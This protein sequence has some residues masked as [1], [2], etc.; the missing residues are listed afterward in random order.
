MT[1]RHGRFE[2]PTLQLAGRVAY[3]LV[4]AAPFDVHEG[5][6]YPGVATES[7]TPGR[8]RPA[9]TRTHRVSRT[10]YFWWTVSPQG[11]MLRKL[12][13]VLA[14]LVTAAMLFGLGAVVLEAIGQ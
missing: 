2:N 10:W 12:T 1:N 14:L 9:A 13:G 7:L 3:T 8:R 6:S 5:S 11:R 4:V